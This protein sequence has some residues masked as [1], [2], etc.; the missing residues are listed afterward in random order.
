MTTRRPIFSARAK[1]RQ[2]GYL[3]GAQAFDMF[4]SA[5][6][7]YDDRTGLL[8]DAKDDTILGYISLGN[9]FVGR[10]RVREELFLRAGS[11][12]GRIIS[13]K[14]STDT[15][16][17]VAETEAR[18]GAPQDFSNRI[19]RSSLAVGSTI[20][21]AARSSSNANVECWPSVWAKVPLRRSVLRRRKN[22][23]PGIHNRRRSVGA[24]VG[25]R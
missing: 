18:D 1:A 2:I 25:P 22:C 20:A 15:P 8:R 6:A 12:G 5:C 9:A 11:D 14:Q 23:K 17:V 24:R 7:A 10:S 3:E 16:S 13:A 21:E 19:G 4:G